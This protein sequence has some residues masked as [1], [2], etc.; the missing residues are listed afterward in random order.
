M[1]TLYTSISCEFLCQTGED[2]QRKV[3]FKDHLPIENQNLFNPPYKRGND[4]I[5]LEDEEE[6]DED[7]EYRRLL[8]VVAAAFVGEDLLVGEADLRLGDR[9]RD[10]RPPNRLEGGGDLLGLLER[11]LDRGGLLRRGGDLLRKRLIGLL[12]LPLPK[13]FRLGGLRPR[14][15]GGL[16][17]LLAASTSRTVTS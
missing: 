8:A 13:R 11:R 12:D 2:K 15:G 7:L 10:L 5:Y 6:L 17:R 4:R 1:L 14:G 16:G 3:E 9:E